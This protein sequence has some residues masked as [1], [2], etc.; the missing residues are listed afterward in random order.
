MASNI[1]L[2]KA[3]K[4]IDN[5]LAKETPESFNKWLIEKRKSRKLKNNSNHPSS[6]GEGK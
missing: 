2:E 1:N 6:K 3:Q 4:E 5:L